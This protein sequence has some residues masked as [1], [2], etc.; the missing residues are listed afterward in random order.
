MRGWCI[1]QILL[2]LLSPK[3]PV[4]NYLS[5]EDLVWFKILDGSIHNG[6]E[7]RAEKFTLGT[8]GEERNKTKQ[9]K[10]LPSRLTPYDYFYQLDSSS[11]FELTLE[12]ASLLSTLKALTHWCHQ[13]FHGLMS[14]ASSLE[15]EANVCLTTP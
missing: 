15:R 11:T 14:Q 12:H 13:S 6:E 5:E 8:N 1:H 3:V 10:S 4:R 7:G 9:D 2:L